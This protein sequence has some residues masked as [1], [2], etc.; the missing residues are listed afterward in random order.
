MNNILILYERKTR[1]YENCIL[2][3]LILE[4][5]GFN[6]KISHFL[7]PENYNWVGNKS[8]KYMFVP[9][10]YNSESVYRNLYRFGHSDYIINL[11]YEQVLSVKWEMLG[12]HNP[13]GLALNGIHI[14]WGELTHERLVKAGV[15]KLNCPVTGAI[16][17]DLLRPEFRQ[18][19][20]DIK[21]KLALKFNLRSDIKWT[22]F[23]SS[24]T[25]ADI[26]HQ[27]LKINENIAGINLEDIVPYYTDSRNTLLEWFD[28]YLKIHNNE[29]FIYRPHPDELNLAKVEKLQSK[30]L[31]F[32]ILKE[33]AAKSWIESSDLL[34]TW[35]STT[36]VEAQRLNKPC[37]ILRPFELPDYFDSV[38]LKK[39]KFIKELQGFLDIPMAITNRSSIDERY[40]EQYYLNTPKPAFDNI[41]LLLNRLSNQSVKATDNKFN[42]KFF[43]S[44]Y[45]K[46][47]VI[48][49]IFKIY[50]SNIINIS[51]YSLGFN[52]NF[53]IQ[54]LL[55]I[56]NQFISK[57]DSLALENELKK[58]VS[59]LI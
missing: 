56:D 39:G 59:G 47:L 40:I 10:L 44:N 12:H 11:Q 55:E 18:N 9:H 31:N 36:V 38:L 26:S 50:K 7:D 42:L 33:G 35:Y 45:F 57:N 52:N 1:E 49:L 46:M 19:S 4:K 30:Y 25:Y 8:Y 14:C 53:I 43:I 29:L 27:R 24:F 20:F 58:R 13:K 21:K 22:L 48:L 23:L 2:L 16:Q 37:Y 28:E 3:K 34:Y 17:L 54:W 5:K 41:V 32:I 15:P 6:C 51:K